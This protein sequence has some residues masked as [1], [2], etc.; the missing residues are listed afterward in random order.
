MR[1]CELCG[2]EV[3]DEEHRCPRCG[4]EFPPEIRSDIR[5]QELL[6]KHDDMSTESLRKDLKDRQSKLM[7][8]LENVNLDS[9]RTDEFN[10]LI[11]EGLG[12]LGI[13]VAMGIG[14][15]L[16]FSRDER[17]F[18]LLMS[19]KVVDADKRGYDPVASSRSYIK[20]AN[21][22]NCLDESER[23]MQMVDKALL[24]EPNN[25]DALFGKAKLLF[26]SKRY[27]A[28]RRQLD[29]L[30]SRRSEPKAMYLAELIEQLAHQESSE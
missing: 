23:A 24:I 22:L 26:Y 7:S 1:T 5:D 20:L 21:A 27:E 18:I 29:K 9:L 10:S 19:C 12:F 14:D 3:G 15:E 17:E 16:N 13:P 2:A 6:G 25:G 28:A 30:I 11:E 8:Y 4:F